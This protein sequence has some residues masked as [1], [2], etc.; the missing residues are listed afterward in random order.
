MGLYS[1]SPLVYALL[2]VRNRLAPKMAANMREATCARTKTSKVPTRV[3]S[4]FNP[5]S[6]AK[7]FGC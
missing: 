2:F 5:Y 4:L 6:M 3:A 7:N 1:L